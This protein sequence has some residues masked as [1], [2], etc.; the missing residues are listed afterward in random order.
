MRST[1]R[2]EHPVTMKPWANKTVGLG[3]L[4]LLLIIFGTCLYLLSPV[5]FHHILQKEIPLTPTSKAFEV[6]NNTVSLPPMYLKIHFFNWTNPEELMIRGKKPI[7]EE[8]GP[9]VFREIREKVDTTFHPENNTVSYFQRRWWFFEPKLTNGSLNDTVTQLNSVAISAKHKV[10][11][12]EPIVQST[13]SYMLSTS[14]V[15]ITK[16][17][18]ELLFAGYDDPLIKLGR[19]AGMGVDI[20]PFDK[21]G[22][23]YMR[24][25]STMFDGHFNMDTGVRDV[26]EFG[27]LKKWNYRDTIKFFKSPCNIV[28]GSAGEFW[29]PYRRKDEIVLFSGDLC[30]PL[31]FEYAQSTYHSGVKGYRYVLGEKSLGNNTRR[32]YPHEQAKY[33]E[34]TTT[35]EDFFEADHSAEVPDSLDE[36]PDVVNIGNCFCNGK[37][38]PV[39]LMNISACRYGAPVFLSLPH[40]YKADPSLRERFK[41][42]NPDEQQHDFFITLEPTTGIPLK[43][44]AKMQVNILLEPSKTV[45]LFKQVPTMYFPVMWFSLEVEGT[46]DLFDNLRKLLSLPD[47]FM[48]AGAFLILAGILV[49]CV[50][51]LLYLLKRHRA[52][53]IATGKNVKLRAISPAGDK[54]ELMYVDKSVGNEEDGHARNDRKLYPSSIECFNM[55][56]QSKLQHRK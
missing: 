31:T 20:P 29:P 21:F 43:V 52:G 30:R 48:Y 7:L 32:R 6:W 4:G 47:V 10:R 27:V 2:T 42:L 51:A 25:G 13:L 9:Y 34:Q 5:L 35:T 53:A 50:L 44:S 11:Y 26:G 19:L 33:I 16:T 17:V 3:L 54:S 22:W 23:F 37:C 8:V 46:E 56:L 40:F 24:N 41:G 45:S 1:A 12:W 15:Y 39:G 36:D 14:N 28:E 38:T 18:N 55:D 49:I